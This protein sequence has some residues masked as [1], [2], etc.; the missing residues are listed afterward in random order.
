MEPG[1]AE[2]EPF[3]LLLPDGRPLILPLAECDP[4]ADAERV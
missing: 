2:D 4:L 3:G 1:G